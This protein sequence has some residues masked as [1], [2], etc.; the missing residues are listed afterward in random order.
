MFLSM[1]AAIQ[2]NEQKN[3][4]EVQILGRKYLWSGLFLIKYILHV[5]RGSWLFTK[6]FIVMCLL[7]FSIE[8]KSFNWEK[9]PA[10]PIAYIYGVFP[11]SFFFLNVLEVYILFSVHFNYE[12]IISLFITTKVFSLSI[13]SLNSKI[14]SRVYKG[15]LVKY[16][17]DW[18][19]YLTMLIWS[20]S[21]KIS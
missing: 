13:K 15:F 16:I 9:C 2:T 7:L 20:F 18:Y 1:T 19:Y 10:S 17:I 11:H 5:Y 6:F 3:P 21:I 12:N 8:Y 14:S 4:L